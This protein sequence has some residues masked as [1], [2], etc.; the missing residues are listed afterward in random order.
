SARVA[1]VVAGLAERQSEI[2]R[3]I[4]STFDETEGIPV[5]N[6][7][8]PL[9]HDATIG[10]AFD[11]LSLLSP[12]TSYAAFGRWLC[13]RSFNTPRSELAAR[14]ELDARLRNDM[15]SQ[16]TFATAYEGCGLSATLEQRA[17]ASAALLRSALAVTG[18]L[19]RA[20]PSRWA[21][22]W[23]RYLGELGWLA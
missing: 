1:V 10:A 4:G 12:R 2:A 3:L 11:A 8:K 19:T 21:H 22:V 15:R 16:L 18:A 9:A 20:T 7:G 5:W 13:S 23:T 14:A 17:P 6:G